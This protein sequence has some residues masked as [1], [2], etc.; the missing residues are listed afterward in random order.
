MRKQEKIQTLRRRA[1]KQQNR[2][3]YYCNQLMGTAPQLC[4]TAEHLIPRSKHGKDSASNVVAAC[5]FCNAMR[6]RKYAFLTPANYREAVYA[7]IDHGLWHENHYA[8][9]SLA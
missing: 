2:R 6:H 3:C 7:F 1:A 4:C 5:K 9:E 8:W